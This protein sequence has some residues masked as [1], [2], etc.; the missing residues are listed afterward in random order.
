MLKDFDNIKD[1][2]KELAEI[3]NSFKSEQVQLR[4]IELLLGDSNLELPRED[5]KTRK[6]V[7]R[8]SSKKEKAPKETNSNKNA[9][10][11]AQAGT[12]PVATITKLYNDDFFNKP[13]TLK[14]I[15]EHCDIN[16]ARRIK[17]RDISGKLARMVRNG[18]LKREK[19]ADGQYEYNKA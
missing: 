11:K 12:G 18:E 4:I 14:D 1:Q 9:S 7:T 5:Q 13:K 2:L 15:I 3:V 10:P 6:K 16:L 8:K 19:N 17:Q